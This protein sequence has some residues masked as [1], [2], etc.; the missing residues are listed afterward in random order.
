MNSVSV[1][2]GAK[3]AT[4][5]GQKSGLRKFGRC[6]IGPKGSVPVVRAFVWCA[7]LAEVAYTGF[8][9]SKPQTVLTCETAYGQMEK[10]ISF[11]EARDMA[12]SIPADCT[13]EVCSPGNIGIAAGTAPINCSRVD[14]KSELLSL[15]EEKA[16]DEKMKQ[17][18]ITGFMLFLAGAI[19][20]MA[21]WVQS[22]PRKQPETQTAPQ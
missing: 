18:V 8:Y 7:V 11:S 15:G 9:D 19:E 5:P 4:D 22:K 10:K 2:N 14:N 1:Q 21:R 16:S 20:F 17:W 3:A 6:L 13:L 12:K